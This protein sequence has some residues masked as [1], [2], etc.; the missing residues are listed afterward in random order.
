MRHIFVINPVAGKGN[1]LDKLEA[2][3]KN[4]ALMLGAE[5]E[6]YRSCAVGDA[7][8]F[9]RERCLEAEENKIRFYACGGDCTVN[10]VF[11][12]TVGFA[13]VG[14]SII[15]IGT[16]NDF[17]K[18]FGPNECFFDI[19]AQI[20][21]STVS[22]DGIKVGEKYAVNMVNFGFDCSVVETVQRIKK[23]PW[24]SSKM[25]YIV[26]VAMEFVKMPGAKL[27]RLVID[28]K[29]YGNGELLL[30]AFANGGFYG[31]GFHNAPLAKPDDGKMDVCLVKRVSRLQFASMIKSYQ[32]GTYLENERVMRVA[33]YH[34][35]TSAD[36]DFT[37]ETNVCMDGEITKMKGMSLEL[38]R[39]LFKLVLPRG[40]AAAY[41]V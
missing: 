17:V 16:G 25:A 13:D 19:A 36:I 5:Y 2:D 35:C 11:G 20:E 37:C 33:E 18:N 28:G 39:G 1:L 31:G 12:G 29:K 4:T 6:I 22:I 14:L 10:E 8:R 34:K 7:K 40:M 30:C 27:K 3:I 15:P 26:G 9:V 41:G 24:I 23:H 38:V 21:G 32:D